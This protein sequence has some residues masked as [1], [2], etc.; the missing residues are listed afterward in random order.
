MKKYWPILIL[1]ILL[2]VALRAP[3]F[4]TDFVNIDENE[5]AMAAQKI[6]DGGLPYKD[7]L[8][9][10]PPVIFY[11]YALSFWLTGGANIWAA[12]GLT[13][14][15]VIGTILALYFLTSAVTG[16]KKG[17]LAAAFAYG[18]FSTLFLPQDM[19]AANCEILMMFP[20]TLSV[21]TLYYAEKKDSC[22]LYL[23]TGIFASLGVLT[24]YQG[25][26]II[27]AEGFYIL[28]ISAVLS[29]SFSFR[30][31]ILPSIILT[32]GFFIPVAILIYYLWYGGALN[33]A[34]EAL[35]YILK[36]AKGPPQSD[37][38]YVLMK[39][40]SRTALFIL[41]GIIMW[42]GAVAVIFRRLKDVKTGN[43]SNTEQR[44][45]IFSILWF[46]VSILPVIVG[47]RIYFHYYFVL[48]PPAAFLFGVWWSERT[49]PFKKWAGAIFISWLIICIS[50]WTIYS[51]SKPYR[52]PGRKDKWVHV[53]RFL[54]DIK[55]P[56]DTLFV[57]GYCPQIYIYSG[58]M[59]A[60]RFTTSDYLTGRSPMTAGLEYDP[61]TPNP[62][63]SFR[64]LMNDFIDAPGVVIFDT[65]S[66]AFPKAWEYLK[67][68]FNRKLPTY[69]VDTSPG[70]YRRYSRYPMSKYDYLS[71]VIKNNYTR[72]DSIEGFD[73]YLR[74]SA[75]RVD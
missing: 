55:A 72:I 36:Y 43:T 73:V 24:K 13:V 5:Y 75:R 61:S 71:D 32:I 7:F 48:L 64:K 70:N 59:N 46:A 21:L 45:V 2:S 19:L 62:P 30:K 41:P 47:G 50:G 67:E 9:Y 53:A 18:V 65:S 74:K 57:W 40:I 44:F 22:L 31:N 25:G 58:L 12:Q 42:Y 49:R 28:I 1:I 33:H 68:D 38:L 10:Q 51:A 63:S 14:I 11:V 35:N 4:L 8:I 6:L 15:F 27:A 60:T 26:V 29:R 52:K 34:H 69:I 39:F 37:S 16:S 17:G 66:N 54:K 56:G 20:I 23:L 3:T